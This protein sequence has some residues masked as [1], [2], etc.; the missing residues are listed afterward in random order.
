MVSL[1]KII[2][3]T[4]EKRES[5]SRIKLLYE[6]R[7]I[8]KTKWGFC[9]SVYVL[10]SHPKPIFLPAYLALPVWDGSC[11]LS[12][13]MIGNYLSMKSIRH[14]LIF[15]KSLFAFLLGRMELEKKVL[16]MESISVQDLFYSLMCFL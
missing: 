4:L 3:E 13:G 8:A 1:F 14:T 6:E 2:W 7:N 11:A 5:K 15:R 16:K 12:Q 9:N 10:I